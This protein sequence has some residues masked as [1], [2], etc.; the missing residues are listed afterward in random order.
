MW[1]LTTDVTVVL[2]SRP[3]YKSQLDVHVERIKL[4]KHTTMRVLAR[5][6]PTVVQFWYAVSRTGLFGD[7]SS[8]W[9]SSG[10]ME[11]GQLGG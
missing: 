1:H 9:R 8:C 3:T 6:T 2:T 7:T 11:F 10:R 4:P 5:E